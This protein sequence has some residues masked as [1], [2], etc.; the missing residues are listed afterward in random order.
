M[1]A[2]ARRS[3]HLA[4]G[5]SMQR[6]SHSLERLETKKCGGAREAII[7]NRNEK[8]AKS[9]VN[10]FL[11]LYIFMHEYDKIIIGHIKIGVYGMISFSSTMTLTVNNLSHSH[12]IR[13]NLQISTSMYW[14]INF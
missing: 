4:F 2:N 14:R 1:S 7:E 5:S 3:S 8:N 13:F 9:A 12:N 10:R 11:V 6:A